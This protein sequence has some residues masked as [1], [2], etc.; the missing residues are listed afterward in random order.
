MNIDA[1]RRPSEVNT[2]ATKAIVHLPGSL[3]V[4]VL[5]IETPQPTIA[6]H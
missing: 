1:L 6:V 5:S 2:L 3:G 4:V